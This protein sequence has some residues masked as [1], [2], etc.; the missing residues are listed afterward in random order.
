M[1]REE[2]ETRR[3]DSKSTS[4]GNVVVLTNKDGDYKTINFVIV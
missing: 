4:H 1:G 3:H 2:S